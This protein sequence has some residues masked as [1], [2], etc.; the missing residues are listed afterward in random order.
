[1][2]ATTVIEVGVDVP[3]ATIMFIEGAERFGLSQLHQ[4]RGRVGRG[5]K[6]SYCFLFPTEQIPAAL[7]RLRRFIKARDG[8]EIAELDLQLRGAG[9]MLGTRQSGILELPFVNIADTVFIE[10]MNTV[11]SEFLKKYS[12]NDF[13]LLKQHIDELNDKIHLE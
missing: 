2:V 5:A 9:E 8:F 7:D 3:N 12:L 4:I 13:P 1:M 6:Q 10:K 11:T